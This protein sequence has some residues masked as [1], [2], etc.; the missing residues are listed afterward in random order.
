MRSTN[1][2]E[3]A[4][5]FREYTRKIHA[6]AVPEDPY[7]LQI[8][9]ACARVKHPLLSLSA[10]LLTSFRSNN[11][12]NTI[13]PPSSTSLPISGTAAILSIPLIHG[14]RSSSGRKPLSRISKGRTRRTVSSRKIL[15]VRSSFPFPPV[16]T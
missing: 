12:T 7:Y 13:T 9:V 8:C 2:R 5:I 1:T 16:G 6:K 15:K 14:L 4:L 10:P 3:V 11:G